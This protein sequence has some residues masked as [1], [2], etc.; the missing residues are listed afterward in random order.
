MLNYTRTGVGKRSKGIKRHHRKDIAGSAVTPKSR[1]YINSTEEIQARLIPIFKL[2]KSVINNEEIEAS[3]SAD[4]AKIIGLEV[5]NYAGNQNISN[6]IKYLF[7]I[8]ELNHT[9]FLEF[10]TQ[11]NKKRI[12]KRFYEFAQDLVN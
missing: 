12:S 3:P 5:Q 2:V 4:L 10:T 9:R 8:Y 7:Q 6:I 11:A 1:S